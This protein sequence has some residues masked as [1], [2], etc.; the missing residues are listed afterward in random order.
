MTFYQQREAICSS[1]V[2]SA[3]PSGPLQ[4]KKRELARLDFEVQ[5]VEASACDSRGI[6]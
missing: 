3:A 6:D 4:E 5:N 2:P 1:E